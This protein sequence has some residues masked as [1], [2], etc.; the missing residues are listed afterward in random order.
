MNYDGNP[1]LR[2][3][4]NHELRQP[5]ERCLVCEHSYPDAAEFMNDVVLAF[6]T[7]DSVEKICDDCLK[8]EY[9]KCE[10][11]DEYHQRISEAVDEDQVLCN[12]CHEI[13]NS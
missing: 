2:Q 13:E 5:S 4:S 12:G 8:Q 10:L 1:E 3:M 6:D 9:F 11:C 7:H